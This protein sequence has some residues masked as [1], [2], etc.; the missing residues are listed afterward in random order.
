MSEVAQT[1]I[2]RDM[3]FYCFADENNKARGKTREGSSSSTK[4]WFRAS[5]LRIEQRAEA[6]FES[7]VD[8]ASAL[9][10]MLDDAIT[11]ADFFK[12]W[13]NS[14]DQALPQFA[15]PVVIIDGLHQLF[16]LPQGESSRIFTSKSR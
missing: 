14:E 7:R 6:G 4:F 1:S 16:D 9:G 15:R 3:Q 8:P 11:R 2:L 12:P 10:A 13:T 5:H